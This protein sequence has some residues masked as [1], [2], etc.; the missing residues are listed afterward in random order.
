MERSIQHKMNIADLDHSSTGFS[1]ALEGG[2]D[3]LGEKT[4]RSQRLLTTEAAEAKGADKVV[5]AGETHMLLHL[6]LDGVGR[7]DDV[8]PLPQARFKVGQ[9]RCPAAGIPMHDTQIVEVVDKIGKGSPGFVQ[10]LGVRL[11]DI[12]VADDAIFRLWHACGNNST[13]AQGRQLPCR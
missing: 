11:S 4:H 1:A 9:V 7:P 5:R 10:G 12:D 6:L 8:Q 13:A 2:H 3:F